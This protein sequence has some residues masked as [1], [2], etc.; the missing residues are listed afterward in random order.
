MLSYVI[1]NG[2]I[3]FLQC[4][5]DADMKKETIVKITSIILEI[6][7]YGGILCTISLPITLK[8]LAVF[9]EE[10]E[11]HY[12]ESVIL[13]FVLGVM[14]VLIIGELR[15]MFR[16][17]RED[18]CFVY[19]NVVSLQRMGTYSFVI[20]TVAIMRAILYF[21]LGIFVVIVVFLV[22]GLFSKVLSFV[23]DKAVAYKLE[24][25]MTI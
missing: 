14:A 10:F 6:M 19:D 9:V 13:F 18:D 25:D 1:T 4:R 21:T 11:T 12:Y 24:N 2:G 8:W 22:A 5:K 23:F 3:A 17:V 15:K 7:F 16:T 20:A